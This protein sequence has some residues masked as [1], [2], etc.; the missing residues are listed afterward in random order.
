MKNFIKC[1]LLALPITVSADY[2]TGKKL[3]E[4]YDYHGIIYSFCRTSI[5]QCYEVE[6]FDDESDFLILEVRIDGKSYRA[7]PDACANY[8]LCRNQYVTAS[9]NLKRELERHFPD[10]EV[11]DSITS[12]RKPPYHPKPY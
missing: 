2:K 6:V 9:K 12:Q 5:N 8:Y 11:G 1:L 3:Y 4:L 7:I 10:I